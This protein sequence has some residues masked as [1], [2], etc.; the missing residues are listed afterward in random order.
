MV[1]DEVSN[2]LE[3]A[4][5]LVEQ[6]SDSVHSKR[7]DDPCFQQ[8][9]VLLGEKVHSNKDSAILKNLGSFHVDSKSSVSHM[10]DMIK[11]LLKK[12]IDLHKGDLDFLQSVQE[13]VAA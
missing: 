9:G 2:F 11:S 4:K 12:G 3:D 5:T 8:V 7:L 6:I 13:A 10:L 1:L